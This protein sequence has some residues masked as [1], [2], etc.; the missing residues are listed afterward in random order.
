MSGDPALGLTGDIAV[1]FQN[2]AA[3]RM[4]IDLNRTQNG[5][6]PALYAGVRAGSFPALG[7]AALVGTGFAVLFALFAS[8]GGID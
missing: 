7:A 5:T 1:N 6:H 2:Y 3:L 8:A 4:R